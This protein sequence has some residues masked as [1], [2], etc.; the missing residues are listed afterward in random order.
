M[1]GADRPLAMPKRRDED[2]PPSWPVA[3][4]R[5]AQAAR[6]PGRA[7]RRAP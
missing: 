6:Q 5:Q 2:S 4:E 1:D 7:V 3:K